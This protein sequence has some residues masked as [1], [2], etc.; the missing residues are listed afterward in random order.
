MLMWKVAAFFPSTVGGSYRPVGEFFHDT[1]F[2]AILPIQIQYYLIHFGIQGRSYTAERGLTY[3][4]FAH[5]N[6]K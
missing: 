6:L 5:R 1:T 2:W 4:P 3:V